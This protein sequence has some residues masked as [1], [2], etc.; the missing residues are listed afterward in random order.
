MMT[1][2][3]AVKIAAQYVVNMY[4]DYPLRGVRLEE[5]ER[6]DDGTEWIVTIGFISF[7]FDPNVAKPTHETLFGQVRRVPR[8][9]KVVR[10]AVDTG[11][12]KSMKNRA[13]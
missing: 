5:I 3:D 1:M 4:P 7:D 13:A 6:S 2:Q 11:E 9:M 12:V 8:D 10:V